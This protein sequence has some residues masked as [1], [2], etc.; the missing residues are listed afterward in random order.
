MKKTKLEQLLG[1]VTFRRT[2][3]EEKR[4]AAQATAQYSTAAYCEQIA[5]GML[6]AENIILDFIRSE[7]DLRSQRQKRKL[8]P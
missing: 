3:Y 8:T 2:Q 5:C 1:Q 4:D 6:T 7:R